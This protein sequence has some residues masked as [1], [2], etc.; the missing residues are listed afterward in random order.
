[1]D[2]RK[3]YSPSSKKDYKT[4]S[5]S[6]KLL[7]KG[8]K[9]VVIK[10]VAQALPTF[11]MSCYRLPKG[12]ISKLRSAIAKFWWST[13]SE[14]RGMHW[15]A[16]D[17]ICVPLDKGGLGF[18]D[19]SNFNTALL[20]KQLWRLLMYPNSLLAHVL[21][22]RYYRFYNPLEVENANSPSFGWRSIISAKT[23]L[24]AGLRRTIGSGYETKVWSYSWI[25][26]IPARP[27]NSLSNIRNPDLYVN[28]LID[29]TTKEWILE[30]IER[31]ISLEDIPLILALKPSKTYR[32]DEYS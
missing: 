18:R 11:L 29:F 22:G 7:S 8:G 4:N 17:K 20:A 9:E 24:Q 25:P 5:W 1:M 23:L 3:K 30:R 15:I 12:I 32:K 2:Q 6:S 16:W 31:T 27:A 26:S 13:K 28:H 14:N 19:L 21:K 10:S